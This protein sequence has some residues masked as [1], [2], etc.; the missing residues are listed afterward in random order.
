MTPNF[1]VS[2]SCWLYS[3][4]HMTLSIVHILESAAFLACFSAQEIKSVGSSG[5]INDM[6]TNA[7]SRTPDHAEACWL[8]LPAGLLAAW[9]GAAEAGRWHSPS[10]VVSS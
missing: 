1:L 3:H 10:I 6:P 8:V 9:S 7:C 4:M 2:E 5:K